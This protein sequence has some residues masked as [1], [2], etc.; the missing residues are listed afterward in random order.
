MKLKHIAF[1]IIIACTAVHVSAQKKPTLTDRQQVTKYAVAELNQALSPPD[2]ALFK[3]LN[4]F[5][6]VPGTYIFDVT[7]RGKGET[8]TVFVVND[9]Q[10]DIRTQNHLKDLL[11]SYRYHF[12]MRRGLLCKFQYTITY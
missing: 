4:Y 7:V 1:A 9:G 11:K 5:N 8:A 12:K 3:S 6:V 2:G 10:N